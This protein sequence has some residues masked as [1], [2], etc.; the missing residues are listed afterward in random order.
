MLHKGYILKRL[1]I[2]KPPCFTKWFF[3]IYIDSG[4]Q[5][6]VLFNH[7]VTALDKASEFLAF[8]QAL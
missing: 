8:Q 6:D 5:K 7:F 1:D 3:W 4:S 2:K